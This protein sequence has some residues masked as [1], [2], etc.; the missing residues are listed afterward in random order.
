[1]LISYSVNEAGKDPGYGQ[2]IL[3]DDMLVFRTPPYIVNEISLQDTLGSLKKRQ[4]P[5]KIT[6]KVEEDIQNNSSPNSLNER[7][8][9]RRYSSTS[10]R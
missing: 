4:K 2:S 7:K 3:H 1:M 5:I 8:V 6:E 10:I 9:N